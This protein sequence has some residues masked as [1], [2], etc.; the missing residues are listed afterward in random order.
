MSPS[1]SEKEELDP[2]RPVMTLLNIITA[3]PSSL[4]KQVGMLFSRLD[5]FSHILV[6]SKSQIK[7]LLDAL[8]VDKIELPRVN[9]T[10]K[11][12][13]VAIVGGSIEHRLF[14]ND[15]SGLYISTSNE[16]IVRSN[17][18]SSNVSSQIQSR[19]NDDLVVINEENIVSETKLES[20]TVIG[21]IISS[22]WLPPY[23]YNI[24]VLSL[25]HSPT[26]A[27]QIL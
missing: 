27:C 11:A 1:N 21:S 20:N 7:S 18:I 22:L 6:W 16:S 10:F 9:L 8:S 3:P 4:F 23:K 13:R 24:I 15:H 12:K 26:K 14:S 17:S 5:N 19:T 25:T 2:N